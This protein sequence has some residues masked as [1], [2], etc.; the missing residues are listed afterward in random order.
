MSLRKLAGQ[1]GSACFLASS[2][3]FVIPAAMHAAPQSSGYHVIRR[4][5]VGGDG[6]WDYLRVDPDAKRIY[7]ARSTHVM[8][9]DETTGKLLADI[10]DTKGVHGTAIAPELNRDLR[11]TACP[12]PSPS[13]T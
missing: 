13:S 7:V 10:T 2:L 11:A 6:A 8:V 5:P 4:I 3:L 12:T 9:I 1:V